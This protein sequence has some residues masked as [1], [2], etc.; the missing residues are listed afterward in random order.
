MNV[1]SGFSR[2]STDYYLVLNLL[3]SGFWVWD[4]H[5]ELI[6]CLEIAPIHISLFVFV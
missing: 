1:S 4:I 6:E 3:D 5:E 2:T